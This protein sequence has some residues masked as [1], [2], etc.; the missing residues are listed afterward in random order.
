MNSAPPG[1]GDARHGAWEGVLV[2]VLVLVPHPE[3]AMR[4]MEG[5]ALAMSP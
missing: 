5:R 4:V 1:G 3:E 2:R